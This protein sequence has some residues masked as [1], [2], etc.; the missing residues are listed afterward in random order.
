MCGALLL[1]G[2]GARAPQD[3]VRDKV[4]NAVEKSK[5]SLG[6][7]GT[8]LSKNSKLTGNDAQGRPLWSLQFGTG[9][10][11]NSDDA[12]GL[13]RRGD[14][15]NASAILFREGR[16]ETS[17]KADKINFSDGAEGLTMTL[18][19]RV[20][21]H[22]VLDARQKT[23]LQIAT[24]S[25]EVDVGR[26]QFRADSPV[27]M[28]QGQTVVVAQKMTADTSLSVARATNGVVATSPQGRVSSQNAVYSWAKNRAQM[29]GN[30]SISRGA[31]RLF[32]QTLDADTDGARGTLSGK[33][34]VT[35]TSAQGQAKAP[36]VL[37]NW[38]AG[39]ISAIGGV[40]MRQDG[41]L[42]QARQIDSDDKLNRATA[43]GNVVLTRGD[44]TVRAARLQAFDKMTRIVATDGVTVVRPNETLSANGAT[45]YLDEK[46]AVANGNVRLARADSVLTSER[47]NYN[48]ASGVATATGNVS[49]RRQ[50]ATLKANQIEY[51][52]Q[53]GRAIGSGA[54][55]LTRSDI[56]VVANRV[57]AENLSDRTRT[58]IVAIG[59]VR[60]RAKDG[61]IRGDRVVWS[62][63]G[64]VASGNVE[65]QKSGNV[66]SGA[67]LET[68]AQFARAVLSGG[69]SG[70]LSNGARFSGRALTW[71]RVLD[72][73][74]LAQNGRVVAR[75]GIV[76]RRGGI[77]LRALN[78]D[79]T[80]D[81]S[82]VFLSGGVEATGKDGAN[83]CAQTARYSAAR[84]TIVAPGEVWYKDAAGN[85]LQGRNFQAKIVGGTL[86]NVTLEKVKGQ[87]NSQLFSGKTLFGD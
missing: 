49:I 68:D 3:A 32:G 86:Q 37:Y 13:S 11:S 63:R 61:T 84:A 43:T 4:K 79:A 56:N 48:L 31:T 67:R 42:L 72:G 34:G 40:S 2:C 18:S 50:N 15:E 57:E 66:L 41:A 1:A 76:L 80:G 78:L 85:R 6:D 44:A 75:G 73:R 74:V 60:A 12:Q 51:S 62:D 22:R 45:V 81:G 17:L 87:G 25:L 29:S 71:N 7:F 69:V 14:L 83:V 77:V 65:L 54:V 24:K 47:A 28:T 64:A 33:N 52:M 20:Q 16:A 39:R 82:E 8:I 23:P 21:A 59:D 55:S 10:V 36:R 9:K 53:S 35:A 30:V 26:R 5:D 27:T 46:R 70:V 38:K 19:G 58:Q